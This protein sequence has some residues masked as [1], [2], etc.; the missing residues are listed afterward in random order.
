VKFHLSGAL[1]TVSAQFKALHR[2]KVTGFLFSVL[3]RLQKFLYI[4]QLK[5]RTSVRRQNNV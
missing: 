4:R 2:L 3:I 1:H 5:T